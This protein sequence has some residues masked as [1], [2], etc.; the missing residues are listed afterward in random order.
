MAEYLYRIITPEG[1]EKKGTIEAK[2]I[3]AV[4]SQLRA[5]KNIVLSVTTASFFSKDLDISFGGKIKP[6]EFS[7]FCRQFASILRAGVSLVI[8]LEMLGEQTENKRLKKAIEEL[9]EDVSKGEALGVAMRNKKEFPEMLCNMIEAGEMSGSLE[10]S[11][12]RMA[13]QF[14]KDNK[15]KAAVQKAMIYPIVVIVVMIGVL[16]AMMIFVIPNFVSMFDGMG[17]ELPLP[18]Q[19]VVAMSDFMLAKWW[20]ALIIVV[21]VSFGYRTFAQTEAG[22]YIVSGIKLKLPIFG[23]LQTK[24][25]CARLGRTLCTL[26]SAGVPMIE[27]LEITGKSMDNPHFKKVMLDAKEQVSQGVPLSKPLKSS[28]LFPPM[29]THMIAIGEE[30]GNLE[31]WLETIAVYYEEDVENTTQ[32]LTALMEPIIIVVMALMVGGLVMAIMAPMLQTFQDI[33]NL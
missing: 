26:F 17:T 2:N 8:A 28:G 11:F 14:E 21:G 13:E 16:I 18:T 22:K 15:L 32:Q 31:E 24:S 7:I 12:G 20:L 4:Q 1:K 23:Q 19:I 30:T 29:V 27:A 25:S 6:R 10:N 3:E 9:H 33:D 5:E